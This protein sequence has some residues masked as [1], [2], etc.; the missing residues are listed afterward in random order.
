MTPRLRDSH[1][2]LRTAL[3]LLVAALLPA[4]GC[5]RGSEPGTAAAPAAAGAPAAAKPEAPSAAPVERPRSVGE[6][7]SRAVQ[8]P[9][10]LFIGLDGADWQQLDPLIERGEMPNLAKLRSQSAWGELETQKPPLSPLLWTS[11]MTGV[12]PVVH[13][14]LDFSRFQP[15]TGVREPITSDERK[16]PALWN[17]ATWAGKKRGRPRPVG[18]LPGRTGGR[19][20]GVGSPVRL[21]QHGGGAAARRHLS[22][23]SRGLGQ[24]AAG[25]RL[26]ADRVRRSPRVPAL[27]HRGRVP[28]ARGVRA[29]VR[30]SDLG[31]AADPGRDAPLRRARRRPARRRAPRSVRRL[32]AGDRLDRTRLRALRAAATGGDPRGGLRALQGRARALLPRDRRRARPLDRRRRPLR[33][34]ARRGLRPRLLL[35][36]GPPGGAFELRQRHRGE[37]ASQGGDLAGP[38]SRPA[39]T[40]GAV[41]A[42]P[43]LLDPGLAARSARRP[44]RGAGHPR[45]SSGAGEARARLRPGLPRAGRAPARPAGV[46]DRR[47]DALGGRGDR[48]APGAGLHRIGRAHPGPRSG[49]SV[50]LDAH[51]RLVQQRGDPAPR[52]PGRHRRPGGVREGDRDRPRPRLR[53]VEPL[54]PALRARSATTAPTSC[55]CAPSTTGCRRGRSS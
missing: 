47:L 18:D 40:R 48:Q 41:F 8:R 15:G 35:G 43:G 49:P 21:P 53:A 4:A 51:R 5:R 6:I 9:P 45:R 31:A 19:R 37:V 32:P 11:M 55:W 50:R 39:R 27:A 25:S 16:V 46:G 36:R 28:R 12:S 20:A 33:R 23:R 22:A 26:E 24:A 13:G 14:I 52:R 38:G 10:V 2:L 7:E 44:G 54:R 1:R 30:P 42:A 17:L 29:S 34:G 3:L